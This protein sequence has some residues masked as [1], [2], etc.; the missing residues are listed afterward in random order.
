MRS[1]MLHGLLWG[2]GFCLGV[3]LVYMLLH[4]LKGQ[5]LPF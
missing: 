3:I 2:A 5:P 4:L 1:T